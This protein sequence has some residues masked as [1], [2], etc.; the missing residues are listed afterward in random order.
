[1]DSN[2]KYIK[3]SNNNMC[4]LHTQHPFIT[5]RYRLMNHV[6]EYWYMGSMLAMSEM[7]KNKMEE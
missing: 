4:L 2:K 6:R 3:T 5:C 7:Q 1:M